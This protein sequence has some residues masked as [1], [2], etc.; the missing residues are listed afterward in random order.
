MKP[1]GQ[2]APVGFV[3]RVAL[4]QS[5]LCRWWSMDAEQKNKKRI[6]HE[7]IVVNAATSKFIDPKLTIPTFMELSKLSLKF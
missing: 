3:V 6:T 2:H 4:V 5:S 7:C 1:T